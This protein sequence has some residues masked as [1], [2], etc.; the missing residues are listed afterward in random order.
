MRERN[1]LQKQYH[2]KRERE[3]MTKGQEIR[4]S[5]KLRMRLKK[6]C[7]TKNFRVQRRND[8]KTKQL[9]QQFNWS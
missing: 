3:V 7:K 1:T 8:R 6:T 4:V 9:I 5:K 2:Q